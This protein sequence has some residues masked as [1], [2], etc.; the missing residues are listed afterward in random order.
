MECEL[1]KELKIGRRSAKRSILS[2]HLFWDS[3]TELPAYAG[4]HGKSGVVHLDLVRASRMLSID[5][6]V[7]EG[8]SG[9]PM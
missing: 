1:K 5:E 9:V 7:R 8:L 3:S 4:L 6:R 2:T